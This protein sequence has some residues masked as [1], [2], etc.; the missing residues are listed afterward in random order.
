[1]GREVCQ[2]GLG[3]GWDGKGGVSAWSG[4]D[5]MG[6]EVSTYSP[7]WSADPWVAGGVEARLEGDG[8][9]GGGRGDACGRVGTLC[10]IQ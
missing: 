6:R 5:G 8:Q 9:V 4:G 3:V 7:A 1:M 10:P 2:H